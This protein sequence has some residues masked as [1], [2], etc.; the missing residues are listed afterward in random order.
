[1]RSPGVCDW[2]CESQA[3]WECCEESGPKSDT[4]IEPHIEVMFP[5]V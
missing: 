1:M 2:L 4:Y 5:K 3:Q